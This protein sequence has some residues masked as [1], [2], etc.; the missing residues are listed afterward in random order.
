MTD[1]LLTVQLTERQMRALHSAATM[2]TLAIDE[3][4]PDFSSHL[5]P[6]GE[7]PALATGIT[8]LEVALMLA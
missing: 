3:Q 8:A 5:E 4:V 2:F 6:N 1:E 7:P